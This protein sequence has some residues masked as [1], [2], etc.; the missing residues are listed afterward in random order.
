MKL[1]QLLAI[2]CLTLLSACDLLSAGDSEEPPSG[3]TCGGRNGLGQCL[4]QHGYYK[5]DK[6]SR[7]KFIIEC[8]KAANPMSD[9]EGE[10]LVRQC[11]QTSLELFCERV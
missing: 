10:D 5:C 4:K 3:L 9:E 1:K 8:A 11:E 7:A 2:T 6:P